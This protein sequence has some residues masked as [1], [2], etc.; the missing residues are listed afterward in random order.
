MI[1]DAHPQSH[2]ATC[3]WFCAWAGVGALGLL[4]LDVGPIAAVPALLLAALIATRG[5]RDHKSLLGLVT[6]AGLPLLYVAWVQREG[7]GTTCWHTAM[8]EGCN[9]HLN[10]IPWLLIGLAL[11]LAGLVAQTR[12]K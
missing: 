7:P 2:S 9:Q 12:A 8:G 5:D 3:V 6:G 4:S 10:P 11:V 1:A